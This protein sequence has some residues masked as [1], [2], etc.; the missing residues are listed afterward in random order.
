MMRKVYVLF[1]FTSWVLTT[2]VSEDLDLILVSEPAITAPSKESLQT[3]PPKITEMSIRTNITNRFAETTVTSKLKNP[4]TKAQETTFFIV[5]PEQAFISS[6]IMELSGKNYTAFVEEKVKAKKNYVEAVSNGAGAAHVEVSARDSNLFCVNINVEAESKAVFYLTYEELLERKK[7]V[8]ELVININPKQ[9]VKKLNVEVSIDE[10][11]PITI[12][13]TPPIR[14]GNKIVKENEKLDARAVIERP[15]LGKAVIKF[16]PDYEK[17]KQ[18]ANVLGTKEDE[19]LAGQFVVQYDVQ[20]DTNGGTIIVKDGYFVHFFAPTNLEPIP[21]HVVFV[22]DT[23]VSMDG[24]K[25]DQVKEAMKSIVGDLNPDDYFNIVEFNN[26]AYVWNLDIPHETTIYPENQNDLYSQHGIFKD[27]NSI[28]FP[29]AYPVRNSTIKKAMEEISYMNARGGTNIYHAVSVGLHLIQV[30]QKVSGNNKV[31]PLIIFLTDGDATVG[32]TDSNTIMSKISEE[33][34]LK[35]PI[36]SLAFGNDA[37]R[38][39]IK[40]LSINNNGFARFI[41]KDSDS[42]LQLSNFYKE[43]S[44]LLLKNVSFYYTQD[45]VSLTKTEFPILFSGSEIIVTGKTLG[46]IV[47]DDTSVNSWGIRGPIILKP[48]VIESVGQLERLWAYMTVKRYLDDVSNLTQAENKAREL[49][50][51]YSFVTSVTSLV[52]VKPNETNVIDLEEASSQPTLDL[53]V[54]YPLASQ[55]FY[56][57]TNRVFNTFRNNKNH[58]KMLFS[59]GETDYNMDH[60]IETKLSTPKIITIPDELRIKLPILEHIYDI[61]DGTLTLFKYPYTLGFNETSADDIECITPRSDVG[62][63]KLIRDCE[64]LYPILVN[65]Q[66]FKSYFCAI[67]LDDRRL[68]GICCPKNNNMI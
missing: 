58:V 67:N 57:P 29:P 6:F 62:A 1:A 41:Y 10:S 34:I 2:A 19:G 37:D 4:L 47:K 7:G 11:V 16:K 13:K 68:G 44:S 32:I 9:L 12:V 63:C 14:S 51:K 27:M 25:L 65:Q 23:S 18:I 35:I 64:I 40:E 50:L 28:N 3:Q 66:T 54:P 26:V 45:F 15:G 60:L 55:Q 20:R 5:I 31:Q 24:N 46:N 61:S 38:D 33:N 30:F 39:L 53:L 21:K 42:Y 43:I 48:N 59:Y 52:V 49:A 22:L 17:Q 36:I 56:F 8:Y